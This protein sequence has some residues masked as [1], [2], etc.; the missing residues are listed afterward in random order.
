MVQFDRL[1]IDDHGKIYSAQSSELQRR[2]GPAAADGRLGT[3]AVRNL[4]FVA[5]AID[6]RGARVWLSPDTAAPRAILTVREQLRL[7]KPSRV[8]LT[9]FGSGGE[10]NRL[11]PGWQE[12][13]MVIATA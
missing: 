13:A 8:L 3:F 11:I 7:A 9:T 12:A 5:F 6:A 1:L 4:G 10:K 2:L